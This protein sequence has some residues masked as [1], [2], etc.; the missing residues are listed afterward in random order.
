VNAQRS[1]LLV[2]SL[3][4]G[5]G[6]SAA[7]AQV[8]PPLGLVRQ[9][10]V[11]GGSAVTGSTGLGTSV[12]GDVGSSPTPS[13][14]NFP[15]SRTVAPFIVHLTNDAV[16]QQAHLDAIT[17]YNNLFAQGTGAGVTALGPQLNGLNLA[18]GIYRFSSSADLAALGTLTLTDPTGTGIYIFSVGSDLTI[19]VGSQFLGNANPCNVYWQ[20]GSSATLNGQNFFGTVIADQS[21]TVSSATTVSG[22]AVA[23]NAAVTMPAAGG[24][25]IGGCS[26]AV[27]PPPSATGTGGP[28]LD[29]VGL[30]ILLALLATA[31][32]FAANRFTL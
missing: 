26:T 6:T 7:L 21:V 19:N 8:A 11:L 29:S 4:L 5:L 17:A 28:T 32:V 24:N 2:F 15:P 18:P 10:G 23:V 13:V 22:R 14:S 31:G 27:A 20:V 12:N 1:S 30:V 25:T 16:V 3:T 9:F